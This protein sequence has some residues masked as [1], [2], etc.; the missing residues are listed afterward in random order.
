M[1]KTA[2]I[3]CQTLPETIPHY[4]LGL[5]GYPSFIQALPSLAV[6]L[7]MFLGNLDT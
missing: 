3:I 4:T 5:V 7:A 1:I 6:N 2:I